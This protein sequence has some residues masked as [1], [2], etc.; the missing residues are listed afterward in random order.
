MPLRT[1]TCQVS[2]VGRRAR[3][4]DGVLILENDSQILLALADGMGGHAGG[5]EASRIVLESLAESGRLR[6]LSDGA[7]LEETMRGADEKIRKES[8][9]RP[10]L[11]GMGSTVVAVLWN[12]SRYC[13][14]WAGDSRCYRF[15]EQEAAQLTLDHTAAQELAGSRRLTPDEEQASP[16]QG[17]LTRSIGGEGDH[18][19]D[20][21]E[22]PEPPRD[23]EIVLL[24]SDG[25]HA[26]FTASEMQAIFQ[27]TSSLQDGV[28][29]LAREAFLRG[30]ND[31]ISAVGLEVG[32]F[33][34]Q[35]GPP[36]ELP[37]VPNQERRENE[38]PPPPAR[39]SSRP[40]STVIGILILLLFTLG[41]LA[42]MVLDDGAGK[43]PGSP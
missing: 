34:R 19:A 18:D 9:D 5:K 39:K 31:N 29:V 1:R 20:V 25:L 6:K 12:P 10:E 7:S 16:Y 15:R 33:R 11:A 38:S 42:W 40:D 3:N 35:P 41:A 43:W 28:E 32:E 23:G 22:S 8:R 36:T 4:E 27:K 30:S 13:W 21:A 2:Y 14:G 24:T 17:L 37:E 26:F